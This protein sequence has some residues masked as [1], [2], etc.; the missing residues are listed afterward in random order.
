MKKDEL[1]FNYELRPRFQ[2]RGF[3]LVSGNIG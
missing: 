2:K 1:F 3:D